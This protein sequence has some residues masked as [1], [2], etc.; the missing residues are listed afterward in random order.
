MVIG[1][2]FSYS[3][4][5][6]KDYATSFY[7]D[8]SYAHIGFRLIRS[9]EDETEYLDGIDHYLGDHFE[10]FWN[11]EEPDGIKKTVIVEGISI[12]YYEVDGQLLGLY[13]SHYPNGVQKSKGWYYKNQRV[14]T[15]EIWDSLGVKQIERNY[16]S[17][18]R[19]TQSFP[20]LK[21]EQAIILRDSRM[22][23][24]HRNEAGFIAYPFVQER[25]VLWSQRYW[26]RIESPDNLQLFRNNRLAHALSEAVKNGSLKPFDTNSDQ[27]IDSISREEFLKRN[28]GIVT[29]FELKS[30]VFYDLDRAIMSTRIIGICPIIVDTVDG[31]AFERKLAWLYFPQVR[32]VLNEIHCYSEW[33]LYL[34]HRRNG[35]KSKQGS[36][37]QTLD[38]L[39]FFRSFVETIQGVSSYKGRTTFTPEESESTGILHIE[40]EHDLWLHLNSTN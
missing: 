7:Q 4:P 19:F 15:W 2:N 23:E 16:V 31:I 3:F 1:A 18:Y 14:G 40:Q 21:D 37:P 32:S 11:D 24:F 26:S 9:V 25:S 22:V 38:D 27:F 10:E 5:E 12:N 20:K 29:V 35:L 8:S 39:F 33:E 34:Y 17:P 13:E 30:D 28:T 6:F 36:S